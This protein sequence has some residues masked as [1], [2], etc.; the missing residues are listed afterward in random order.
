MTRRFEC[1]PADGY[2]VSTSVAD[3]GEVVDDVVEDVVE[4]ATLD[5]AEVVAVDAVEPPPPH[6]AARIATPSSPTSA[7]IR[8]MPDLLAPM[9]L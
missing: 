6:A 5:P 1:K 3:A 4:V 7:P 2:V 8:R 9:S